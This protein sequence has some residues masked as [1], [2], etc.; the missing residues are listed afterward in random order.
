MYYTAPHISIDA[1]ELVPGDIAI[2]T[3]GD[4]INAD[5]RIFECTNNFLVD[6]RSIGFLIN[7]QRNEIIRMNLKLSVLTCGFAGGALCASLF[8]MNLLSSI[9]N[10]PYIF[11]PSAFVFGAMIPFTVWRH[12]KIDLN[13][14]NITI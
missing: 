12:F 10:H 6:E 1:T 13:T 8:G 7:K 9:E 2:I 5:M 3:A 4:K 11:W 14:K